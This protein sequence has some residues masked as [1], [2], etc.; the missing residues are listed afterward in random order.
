MVEEA[1]SVQGTIYNDHEWLKRATRG[2]HYE[3]ASL[4][5]TPGYEASPSFP[6][7]GRA[8]PH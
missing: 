8:S 5:Y 1:S 3:G 6:A 2:L 4:P 7:E